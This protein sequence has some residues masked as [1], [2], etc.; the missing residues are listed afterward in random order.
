MDTVTFPLISEVM[1]LFAAEKQAAEVDLNEVDPNVLPGMTARKRMAA[2][3]CEKLA[4][5]IRGLVE[6]DGAAVVLLGPTDHQTQFAELAEDEGDA[7]VISAA[8]LYEDVAKFIEPYLGPGRVFTTETGRG[9]QVALTQVAQ[10]LQVM[11][12]VMPLVHQYFSNTVPTLQDLVD[13]VRKLVRSANN[14]EF[15]AL[16]ISHKAFEQVISTQ[17]DA[18]VV[19]VVVTDATEEEAKGDLAAKLFEGRTITVDLKDPPEKN[20]IV[21]VARKLK[22]LYKRATAVVAAFNAHKARAGKAQKQASP[23][24][25]NP[26]EQAPTTA[27]EATNTEA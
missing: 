17:Y 4:R 15:N 27:D 5:E 25:T 14:D 13:V 21:L 12:F 9:L 10:K 6:Q 23:D 3:R 26:A 20:D 24:A 1:K 8:R 2:E 19:T 18:N 22:P 11:S 16:Y 7:I